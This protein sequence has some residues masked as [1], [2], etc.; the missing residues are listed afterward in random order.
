MDALLSLLFNCALECVIRKDRENQVGLQLNGT[1]QLLVYAA[2]VNLLGGNI[3]TT[4]KHKIPLTDAS[5][6]G[7]PEENAEETKCI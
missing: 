4:K 1:H 2:D 5:N 6:V 3:N 7:G